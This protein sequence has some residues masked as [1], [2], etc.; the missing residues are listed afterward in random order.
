MQKKKHV[1][2][3]RSWVNKCKVK[4]W[5]NFQHLRFGV[6]WMRGCFWKNPSPFQA[7]KSYFLLCLFYG[8]YWREKLADL[9]W[10]KSCAGMD[11][12]SSFSDCLTAHS[13]PCE[14]K[15]PW[16]INISISKLFLYVLIHHKMSLRYLPPEDKLLRLFLMTQ[17]EHSCKVFIVKKG[18]TQIMA[19]LRV[20][21]LSERTYWKPFL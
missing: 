17:K 16:D 12:A 8:N 19:E 2:K 10:M 14:G 20:S 9:C 3:T 6:I 5:L 18:P 21:F 4:V 11:L 7:F 15:I 13:L 1:T